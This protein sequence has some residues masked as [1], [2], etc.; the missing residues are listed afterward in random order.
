LKKAPKNREFSKF[1][2]QTGGGSDAHGAAKNP[3]K[4]K[5]HVPAHF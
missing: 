3:R 1:P 4:N 2:R 5:R